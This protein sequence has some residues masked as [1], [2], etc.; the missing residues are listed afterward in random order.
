MDSGPIQL[1][2]FSYR[3]DTSAEDKILRELDA[4]EGRGLLRLLD[5]LF[6]HKSA[7][8]V[9]VR[10]E[11]EE[12]E[13]GAMLTGVLETSHEGVS[14]DPDG[15]PLEDVLA[16]VTA[17]V[18]PGS[19]MALVLVEHLW[20][21]GL[22]SAVKG[23]GGELVS[24]GLITGEGCAMSGV[25]A[26]HESMHLWHAARHP[27][28]PLWD[29]RDLEQAE[30]IETEAELH[31]LEAFEDLHVTQRLIAQIEGAASLSPADRILLRQL[32]STLSFALLAD[33]LGVSRGAL[34]ERASRLY[35]KLGVHS[36]A[37]AAAE[38]RRLGLGR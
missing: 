4:L 20:A 37:E 3:P 10:H 7:D 33:E 9:L 6:V 34:K 28:H 38:A 17:D 21:G 11:L 13:H 1:L 8:G 15:R 32:G 27:E 14:Y 36:R 25:D 30:I 35:A 16:W 22:F 18:P 26:T 29:K 31:G 12:E 2:A 24:E 23:S 5:F 19:A